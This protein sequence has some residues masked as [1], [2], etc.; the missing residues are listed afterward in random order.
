MTLSRP[1][2]AKPRRRRTGVAV[3]GAILWLATTASATYGAPVELGRLTGNYVGVSVNSSQTDIE[4][5][6][7]DI[8]LDVRPRDR[9]F[10][11]D[12]QSLADAAAGKKHHYTL[13]FQRTRRPGIFLAGMRC[14]AFGHA[15]PL[16]PMRGEPYVW[17]YL[18]GEGLRLYVM[19]IADDGSHDLGIYRYRLD[20][21]GMALAFEQ[22]RNGRSALRIQVG[23]RKSPHQPKAKRP[24]EHHTSA[25][26]G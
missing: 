17:T 4:I 19:S 15:Q 16:D 24:G 3:C 8:H 14:D 23:M 7:A 9:G 12:W 25:I 1:S 2:S 20:R 11:L 22:L 13:A 5:S 26:C 18:D 6:A 21:D 10:I